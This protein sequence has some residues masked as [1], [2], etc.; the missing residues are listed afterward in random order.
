MIRPQLDAITDFPSRISGGPLD[1]DQLQ[2]RISKGTAKD[3]YR[4]QAT[5]EAGSGI[6]GDACRRRVWQNQRR[7][8]D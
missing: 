4:R 7:E 8:L 5:R 6:G 2:H 1:G 3:K